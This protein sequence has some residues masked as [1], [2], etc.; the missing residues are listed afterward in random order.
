MPLC[1]EIPD[2]ATTTLKK[3]MRAM[4]PRAVRGLASDGRG[5]LSLKYDKQIG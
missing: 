4:S 3:P 5:C 2:T 1:Y